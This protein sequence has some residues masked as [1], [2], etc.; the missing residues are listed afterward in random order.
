[1]KTQAGGNQQR[2]LA[3]WHEALDLFAKPTPST[4]V[5]WGHAEA[6][7]W[8]SNVYSSSGDTDKASAALEKSISL[9]PDFVAAKSALAAL[10]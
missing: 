3:R 1:M 8:L 6:Y 2:G 7:F 5:G 9:R 10:R 4:D